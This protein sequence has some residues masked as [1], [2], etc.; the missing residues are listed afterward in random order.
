MGNPHKGEVDLRAGDKDYV[1][2][3][4]IDAICT[5]EASTGKPFAVSAAEMANQKTA[6]MTLTRM[7][8]HAALHENH[9][10]LTLKEAGELIPHAGGMGEVNVKVF[11][12]FALAFPQPE[13][14]GTPRPTNRAARR[15]AGTGPTS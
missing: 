5:L 3:F 11:E 10:E 12:A 7:L 13:A 6:S 8:L 2:R 4:S 15:K 14:S 9:P 1:L